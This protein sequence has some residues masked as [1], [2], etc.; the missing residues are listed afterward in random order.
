MSGY[1]S[2]ALSLITFIN[3]YLQMKGKLLEIQNR[4][5]RENVT[6]D[7]FFDNCGVWNFLKLIRYLVRPYCITT[8][9]L[10]KP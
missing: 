4:F 1:N 8:T 10:G 5:A 9:I 3:K 2:Y 7:E 6:F